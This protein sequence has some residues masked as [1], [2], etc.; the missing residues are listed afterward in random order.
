[1]LSNEKKP[2]FI[3]KS[4]WERGEWD[5]EPDFEEFEYN[6]IRCFLTRN[7]LTG[8]W[9]GY[10]VLPVGHPW[11]GKKYDDIDIEV[12]GGLTFS[13]EGTFEGDVNS[14]WIIGFDC[15]HLSD[16]SPAAN[17]TLDGKY[18]QLLTGLLEKT[19]RPRATYKNI[20]FSRHECKNM[21]D[22][23]ISNQR[24]LS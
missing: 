1:M 16:I 13:Q 22:Q 12:H 7:S 9:C 11:F 10:A 15:A 21:V 23:I 5:N 8:S 18:Q 2:H 4:W 19:E 14:T 17:F 3:D 6:N 24:L 20:E